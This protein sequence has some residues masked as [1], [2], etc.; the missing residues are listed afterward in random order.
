MI[1][2]ENLGF[3]VLVIDDSLLNQAVLKNILTSE[4][5]ASAGAANTPF[6]VESA[7]SGPEGLG[8]VLEFKPDLILLDIIMPGMSGFDVIVKLKESVETK[9]I[10]VIIITGLEDADNEEKGLLLGAVDYITKPFKETVVLARIKTHRLIVE[11]MRMIEKQSLIDQLTNVMNRRSFDFHIGVLWSQATRQQ[12][13]LSILMIDIDHFK[14]FNDTYGHQMGDTVLQVTAGAISASLSRSSD[15]VFRWGGE[16]F[17]VLLP[18]TTLEGAMHVAERIRERIQSTDLP[19][20]NGMSA[21]NVTASLGCAS[22][23]PDA[24][25]T[26]A[27]MLRQADKAMYDAKESGRNRVCSYSDVGE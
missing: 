7:H 10:P 19:S 16:E 11:Q 2:M 9:S 21:P 22:L 13:N 15:L 4:A 1:E 3:K 18:N 12:E 14:K 17:T 26:V 24:D 5:A 6:V 20:V 27:E 8:K 25:S 23:V